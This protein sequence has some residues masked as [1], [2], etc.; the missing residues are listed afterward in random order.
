[1][2]NSR[3]NPLRDVMHQEHICFE[4]SGMCKLIKA[5]TGKLFANLSLHRVLILFPRRLSWPLSEMGY[6]A[7]LAFD[8]S[9]FCYSCVSTA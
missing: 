1:M 6:Q 8:L 2:A 9:Y 7:I 4:K 5:G 3:S